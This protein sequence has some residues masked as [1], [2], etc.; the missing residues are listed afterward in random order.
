MNDNEF[1][2]FKKYYKTN[3]MSNSLPK[4]AIITESTEAWGNKYMKLCK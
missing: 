4:L 2:L 3:N 1:K